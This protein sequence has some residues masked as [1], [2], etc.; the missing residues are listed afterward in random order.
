MGSLQHYHLDNSDFSLKDNHKDL[1]VL[2]DN[3][4]KFRAHIRTPVNKAA[5]LANN[6]LISTLC[7]CSDFMLTILKSHL[8]PL[9]EF[10]STVWNTGCLSG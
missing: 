3:N 7:R 10:G 1:G 4:L 9:L 5:G 2:V 6:I 8:R